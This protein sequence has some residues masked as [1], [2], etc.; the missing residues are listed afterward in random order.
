[1]RPKL[2]AIH[3]VV[4]NGRAAIID[5]GPAPAAPYLLAT[6]Q[7]QNIDPGDV[8]YIFLTH[9]HLDHAGGAGTLMESLPN[10]QAVIHPAGAPH[11]INPGLLVRGA[12]AVYGKA[13]FEE[14]YG[15]IAPI[16]AQRVIEIGD[17]E[18][19]SIGGRE[20][21]CFYTEGH[22]RHH[23][24]IHD[25]ES[26]GV[27]TGDSFGVSYRELDTEAGEFIFPTTSPIHFDPPEAH[28]SVDRIMACGPESLYLTH[29]SRIRASERLADDMHRGIDDL[30]EIAIRHADSKD[31]TAEIEKHMFEYFSA[32]LDDHG[33][34]GDEDSRH[35][36]LDFD[37]WLNTMGL[38]VWLDKRRKE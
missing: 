38:E 27:F 36:A 23:Y 32:R 16:P 21:R 1:M 28:K 6:L 8:E 19:L 35:T 34:E 18:T 26:K 33:F 17:E 14:W 7:Q 12:R 4:E 5:T 31:R 10:A 22:A 37:V 25:A 2:D 9:V 3:L 20:L 29:Y 11:M 15:T 24:C 13:R 30:A